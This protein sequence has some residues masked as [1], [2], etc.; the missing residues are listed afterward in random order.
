V[1]LRYLCDLA[2]QRRGADQLEQVAGQTEALEVPQQ[3]PEDDG[4]V[5]QE[6][7]LGQDRLTLVL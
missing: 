4:V 1:G 2:A 3:V 7:R 6:L 5:F